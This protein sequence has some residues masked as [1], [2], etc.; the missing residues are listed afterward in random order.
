M[1]TLPKALTVSLLRGLVALNNSPFYLTPLA[2]G[3]PYDIC[4]PRQHLDLSVCQTH[5]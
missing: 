4:P 5:A 1:V 3:S 2:L